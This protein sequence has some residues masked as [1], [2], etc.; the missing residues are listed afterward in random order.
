MPFAQ[1]V[2]WEITSTCN[3]HCPHCNASKSGAEDLSPEALRA[4]AR[5]LGQRHPEVVSLTGGEPTLHPLLPELAAI[6]TGHGVAVQ[7]ITNGT[8]LDEALLWRLGEAG[9]GL[10]WVSLDGPREVHDGLR[11]VSGT[12]D[13]ALESLAAIRR[14]GMRSGVLTTLLAAN[15]RAFTALSPTVRAVHP[16]YWYVW[17]GT[18]TDTSDRWLEPQHMPA[19]GSAL[20]QLG[21]RHR[22][23]LIGDN[24]GYGGELEA[25][26]RRGTGG[27]GGFTGCGAGISVAGITAAGRLKGCMMLPVGETAERWS[28]GRLESLWAATA[29]TCAGLAR[30]VVPFEDANGRPMRGCHALAL[31]RPV[32]SMAAYVLHS[33]SRALRW[34]RLL[35]VA[36]FASTVLLS[37]LFSCSTSAPPRQT[38]P[39]LPPAARTAA[40]NG[41][42]PALP[43]SPDAQPREPV[44]PGYVVRTGTTRDPR[45]VTRAIIRPRRPI[46]RAVIHPRGRL[47]RCCYSRAVIPGCTCHPRNTPPRKP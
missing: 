6:L 13:R 39:S 45:I 19:V 16:D 18:P 40:D 23:L 2:E 5:E 24:I 14:A 1:R 38:N 30:Q 42:R 46:S 9:V 20:V 35:K 8:H 26:R 22:E 11:G 31:T 3:L 37:S 36:S 47:P 44:Q 34:E 4:L 21:R 27:Q 28:P 7:I 29:S 32:R 12:F 33:R 43:A 41:T 10:I 17:L 25:L 15:H